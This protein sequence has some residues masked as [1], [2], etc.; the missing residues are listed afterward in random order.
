MAKKQRTYYVAKNDSWH[1]YEFLEKRKMNPKWRDAYF[2]AKQQRKREAII[3]AVLFLIFLVAIITSFILFNFYDGKSNTGNIVESAPAYSLEETLESSN[4][5]KGGQDFNSVDDTQDY[6]Y[7]QMKVSW[8]RAQDYRDSIND[9]EMRN[10]VQTPDGAVNGEYSQLLVEHPE[11]EQ[12]IND[13][14]QRI[15]RGE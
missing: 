12:Q 13:A 2:A 15:M 14:Y 7:N 4:S 9:P 10:S 11:D 5:I 6:Y 3:C 8:Q 1:T